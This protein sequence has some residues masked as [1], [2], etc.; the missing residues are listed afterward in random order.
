[1]EKPEYSGKLAPNRGS[2]LRTNSIGTPTFSAPAIRSFPPP[3]FLTDMQINLWT[4]ALSDVPVEFFR[5]RHIPMMIQYVRAVEGMMKF[6]DRVEADEEDDHAFKRWNQYMNVVSR[7]ERTLAMDAKM[8]ITRTLHGRKALKDADT[9]KRTIDSA[10]NDAE[11]N[12][13]EDLFY[14]ADNSIPS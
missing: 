12:S 11:D 1:M 8:L 7:L 14:A 5:A 10:G 3:E 6:S 9:A 2:R 13:R 4:A